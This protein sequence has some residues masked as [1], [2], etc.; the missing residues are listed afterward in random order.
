MVEPIS[1]EM[2]KMLRDLDKAAGAVQSHDDRCVGLFWPRWGLI[3]HPDAAWNRNVWRLARARGL[4]T[5]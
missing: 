3:Q 2:A 4:T 1:F 5:L